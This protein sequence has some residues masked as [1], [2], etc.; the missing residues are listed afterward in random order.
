MPSPSKNVALMAGVATVLVQ[1]S[2]QEAFAS[3]SALRSAS[4]RAVSAS[5]VQQPGSQQAGA[6]LLGGALACASFG[7]VVA[8]AGSRR[9]AVPHTGK[10]VSV[11]AL[12][13]SLEG[14]GGP[15]SDACWDPAGLTKSNSEETILQWRSA[16]LKHGRVAMLACGGWFHTAAGLHPIGDA[17]ARTRVSDDPI[18]A[19]QQLPAAGL[20]QVFFTLMCLE[21]MFTF[22]TPAPKD[23]PWDTL[24]MSEIVA[25]EEKP[26][27]KRLQLQ[28][29]NNGRLAM[30]G[31][32]GLIAGEVMTGEYFASVKNLCILA[33]A[34]PG[35]GGAGYFTPCSIEG[36]PPRA[37]FDFLTTS[38]L[39]GPP[40]AAIFGSVVP[41]FNLGA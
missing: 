6:G 28:E 32:I 1:V 17:A 30:I 16:E 29:I 9:R 37:P 40:L 12:P 41:P 15:F 19:L 20:M 23:K 22:V 18:I 38:P 31:I 36:F 24:G 27:Y 34:A 14:T 39:G 21:Y 2:A 10:Q 11:C 5:E 35:G 25:D 26:S 7:S 33:A 13:K 8:I 3:P 4:L